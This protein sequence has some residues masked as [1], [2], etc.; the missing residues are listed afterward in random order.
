MH[1][2]VLPLEHGEHPSH[3]A[4]AL[5]HYEC[6]KLLQ[7]RHYGDDGENHY[8]CGFPRCAGPDSVRLGTSRLLSAQLRGCRPLRSVLLAGFRHGCLLRGAV[9]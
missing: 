4:E 2:K 5:Q 6:P 8:A 3:S 7:L 9:A 1:K